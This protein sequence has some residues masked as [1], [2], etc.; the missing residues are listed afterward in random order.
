M[1]KYK[2]RTG[3]M[4]DDFIHDRIT[5]EVR[6]EVGGGYPSTFKYYWRFGQLKYFS[7]NRRGFFG[8]YKEWEVD[9]VLARPIL[10]E[11]QKYN[12]DELTGGYI[13]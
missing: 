2:I 7:D 4:N 11:L 8:L 9:N 12:K 13:I 3:L 10:E 1:A 6:E 5:V